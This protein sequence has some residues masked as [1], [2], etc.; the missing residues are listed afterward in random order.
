M[1]VRLLRK[2]ANILDGVDVSAYQIG[3]V[4]D[5]TQLEADILCAEGWVE[6]VR[7]RPRLV[8]SGQHRHLMRSVAPHAE[9]AD[10]SRRTPRSIE[11]LREIRQEME[12]KS[13]GEQCRRRAED[14]IRE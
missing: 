2:L 1:R 14:A 4:M 5:V 10:T 6:V 13:F 8:H 3:D 7:Q 11:R 9:A 12:E